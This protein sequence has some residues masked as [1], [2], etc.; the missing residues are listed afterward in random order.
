MRRRTLLLAAGLPAFS[1]GAWLDYRL[2]KP[3]PI[4]DCVRARLNCR[5]ALIADHPLVALSHPLETI[6]ML[7]T[8]GG[9]D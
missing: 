3:G 6:E 5:I 4:P 9:L 2:R 1:A 7:R 8:A